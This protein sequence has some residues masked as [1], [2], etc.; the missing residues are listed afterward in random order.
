ML[1]QIV[2]FSLIGGVFSLIG[3]SLLLTSRRLT[4]KL[5]IHLA[6]FAAGALLGAAFLDLLPETI[7]AGEALGIEVEPLAIAIL[8]G[9]IAF[10]TLERLLLRF[11]G[12]HEEGRAS[13]HL[14]RTPWLLII[15]DSLHNLMDG[16]AIASAFFVSAPL[17]IVTALAVASHEVPSEIGEFSVM[18][19]A[20]WPRRRV[21]L[22]NVF[23]AFMATVGAVVAYGLRGLI[24]PV[25]PWIL[26]LT[27]GIFI[28]IASSDLIPE[29]HHKTRKD[30]PA[31][32]IGL[33]IVGVVV[34]G[35]IGKLVE[36]M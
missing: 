19:Q 16:I 6:T 10:F 28:Y 2:L 35:V 27:T 21:F 12:H 25:V 32:V 31:H 7:A 4:G 17:G 3:G 33:L 8:V 18:L 26:A 1:G 34:V 24:E 11:H 30:K 5:L 22:T 36:N 14:E 13:G 29:I 9:I 23:S 15:G 20:G